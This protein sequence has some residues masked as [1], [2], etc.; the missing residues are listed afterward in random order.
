MAGVR[1][2]QQVTGAAVPRCLPCREPDPATQN[3]NG[4]FPRILMLIEGRTR[5]QGNDRLPQHMLMCAE[6][7]LCAAPARC[8]AS[9]LAL[10]PGDGIQGEFLRASQCPGGC[11]RQATRRRRP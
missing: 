11:A 4:G 7:R 10:L 1:D 5:G 3:L 9:P 6:H 2:H 8:G